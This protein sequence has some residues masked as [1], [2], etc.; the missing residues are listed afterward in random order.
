MN[1]C[2]RNGYLDTKWIFAHEMDIST[3]NGLLLLYRLNLPRVFIP[4]FYPS[5]FST[6]EIL[7]RNPLVFLIIYLT[8]ILTLL[9]LLRLDS[10]Q[11]M[12][13]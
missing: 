4:I 13:P 3:R 2:R 8:T 7:R 12:R 10:L 5:I 1:Y 11:R 9:P 6:L